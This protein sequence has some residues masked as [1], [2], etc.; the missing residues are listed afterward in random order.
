MQTVQIPAGYGAGP[1]KFVLDPSSGQLVMKSPEAAAAAPVEAPEAPQET[2][3]FND[4]LQGQQ[5]VDP[6]QVEPVVD[7]ATGRIRFRQVEA[8]LEAAEGESSNGSTP[9]SSPSSSTEV[10]RLREQVESQSRLI[11]AMMIAQAQGK[12][13]SEALGLSQPAA[14]EPDYSQYD[15]YD[16]G[17]RAAFV[18]QLRE[19]ALAQAR[20]EVQAA[21]QPH[22]PALAGAK[23]QMEFLAVQAKH[24]KDPD[25]ARK[26]EVTQRLLQG[27]PNVSFAQTFD[28]VS[29]IHQ[30]LGNKTGSPQR[31]TPN[32][33]RQ[34]TLTPEQADIKAE[35]ARR[36]GQ[37]SGVRGGGEPPLPEHIRTFREA[38]LWTQQ[39]LA[40]GNIKG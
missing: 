14:P 22:L 18:R 9:T 17:Q 39:Q 13:L 16:E 1:Q 12:P 30:S 3:P 37:N 19:D 31:A 21:L 7:D 26:V 28:L 35:Q 38:A 4:G 11:Q 34:T 27:N 33:A 25:F 24:G 5:G 15:L 32:Q 2:S 8:P 29:Q 36:Y 6:A 20:A 40:L 23:Q 10:A